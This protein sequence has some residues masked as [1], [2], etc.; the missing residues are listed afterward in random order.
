MTMLAPVAVELGWMLVSNSASCLEPEAVLARYRDDRERA[1]PASLRAR[2]RRFADRDPCRDRDAR[3]C[4]RAA[5]STRSATG[6]P[7][8]MVWIVGL[9]LR[10]WRKGLDTEAGLI[11]PSGVSAAD[12]LAWWSDHAVEAAERHS[13]PV[14]CRDTHEET[15]MPKLVPTGPGLEPGP[16]PSPRSSRRR[17]RLRRRPGR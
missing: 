15:T 16:F 5:S 6:R 14:T 17:S 7:A 2:G 13:R 4:R 9:L 8:D 1:P 3:P 11:L 10:G 12:D